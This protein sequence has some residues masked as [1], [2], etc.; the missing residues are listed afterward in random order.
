LDAITEREIAQALP[1][2]SRGR[3]IIVSAH[4]LATVLDFDR[5]YVMDHGKVIECGSHEELLGKGSYYS[6][7]WKA[8][9]GHDAPGEPLSET[10]D[11]AWV[12]AV[13]SH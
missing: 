7:L 4:R 8:R 12:A 9:E 11:A 6:R 13:P 2:I 1:R 3:T 10:R 5:I